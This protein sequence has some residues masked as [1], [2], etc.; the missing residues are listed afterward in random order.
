M[1]AHVQGHLPGQRITQQPAHTVGDVVRAMFL[2]DLRQPE[3]RCN[4]RRNHPETQAHR[5]TVTEM[6]TQRHAGTRRHRRAQT[7]R[8]GVHAGHGA[9]VFG[10]VALDDARQQNSDDADTRAA[11][12]AASEQ[13]DLAEVAAQ[14]NPSG[15]CQ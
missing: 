3:H 11:Q 5:P 8:H 7:Q 14:D 13:A 2:P 9:G 1:Q 12:Y 4:Q 15:Q 10:E 6:F